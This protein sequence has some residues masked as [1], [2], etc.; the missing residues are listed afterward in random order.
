MRDVCRKFF[1]E[2][3]D[4]RSRLMFGQSEVGPGGLRVAKQLEE[5]G[6][7]VGGAADELDGV[8][9]GF[10]ERL[11]NLWSACEIIWTAANHLGQLQTIWC[12]CKSFGAAANHLGRLQTI[13]DGCKPFRTP[14][15]AEDL[16]EKFLERLTNL[17]SA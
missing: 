2:I 12:G 11:R 5:R 8:A 7:Q 1:S 17:W 16:P 15:G 10:L 14:D 4:T 9:A 13:W 3:P 6:R